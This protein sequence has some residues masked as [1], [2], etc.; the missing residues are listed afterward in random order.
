MRPEKK[1]AHLL[2]HVETCTEPQCLLKVCTADF[3]RC[4]AL[5]LAS[6]K[7]FPQLA[8]ALPPAA[9]GFASVL[10]EA[11]QTAPHLY[12]K[13]SSALRNDLSLALVALTAQKSTAASLAPF[14]PRAFFESFPHCLAVVRRDA[15]FVQA[16]LERSSFTSEEK[17]E[18]LLI[19][20]YRLT[21]TLAVRYDVALTADDELYAC[22]FCGQAISGL[23]RDASPEHALLC[24]IAAVSDDGLAYLACP[25]ETKA[26]VAVIEHAVRNRMSV[27]DHLTAPQQRNIRVLLAASESDLPNEVSGRQVLALLSSLPPGCENRKRAV[28]ALA[29][30]THPDLGVPMGFCE[31][32]SALV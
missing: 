22:S 23:S 19:N 25:A 5:A 9:L 7:K 27:F 12:S 8:T 32:A 16:V 11:V 6:I 14:V 31:L 1:L 4:E 3:W 21:L 2:R 13:A 20:P 18:L 17:H 24:A 15:R 28:E 29:N 10:Y 30:Q 26:H